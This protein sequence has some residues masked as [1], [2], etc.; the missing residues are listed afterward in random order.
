MQKEKLKV[1]KVQIEL[2]IDDDVCQLSDG[3][4]NKDCICDYLNSK[5]YTDPEFFGD[6]SPENIVEIKEWE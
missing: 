5:L 3:V 4:Y 2:V 1:V 6:F